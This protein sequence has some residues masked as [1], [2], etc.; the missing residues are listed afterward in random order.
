MGLYQ[1]DEERATAAL[2]DVADAGNRV[3]AETEA[4]RLVAATDNDPA[5]AAQI[6]RNLADIADSEAANR[7]DY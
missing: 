7:D 2:Q 4:A 5:S 6:L 1:T 3:A